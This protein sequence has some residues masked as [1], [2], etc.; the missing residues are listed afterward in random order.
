MEHVAAEPRDHAPQVLNLALR[1]GQPLAE[2][3]R[4]SFEPRFGHDFGRVRV[5]T[6]SAA[7]QSTEA[8]HA[9]A[10]T[11]GCD[12][13]FASG[14]YDTGSARGRALLAH[15]LA[16]VVQQRGAR[17]TRVPLRIER[18]DSATEAEARQVG[19]S[20]GGHVLTTTTTALMCADRDAV[21]QIRK[22]GRV[23]GA[24]IRF[25]PPNVTDTV[26]GPVTVQPGL[27]GVGQAQLSVI[28]GQN[29]TPRALARELLPLWTTATQFLP[30]GGGPPVRP[31]ALSVEQLARALI[32]YNQHY[33]GLPSMTSWAAGL[34]FPLPVEIDE[35]TGVATVSPA[36][37]R[38]LAGRFH[39][40]WATALDTRAPATTAPPA[41][42]VTADVAGF[43]AANPS[44][45]ARGMHLAARALTNA[46]AAL[47]IVIETFVQ[48]AGAGAFDVAL[49]FMDTLVNRG[50]GILARQRDGSA[51]LTV[52]R[53]NLASLPPTPTPGQTASLNRANVM[54]GLIASVRPSGRP[55]DRPV[56]PEKSVT[57][58]TVK[59]AGSSH[60]PTTQVQVAN[61]I[62]AQ[63]NVHFVHGA[64]RTATDA[65]TTGW[66]GADRN[67]AVAPACGAVSGEESALYG[68][69]NAT[70]GFG[71]RMRAIFARDFTGYAASGYSLPPYCATGAA[72]PFV[73][74][75]IVANSGDTSTL[76]H[77]LG[78]I[79]LN[80][81][82]HPAGTIMEPRPRPNEITAGQ[83]ATIYANA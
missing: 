46:S 11:L 76:A 30:P 67:V 5:H 10:Y 64:N 7:A 13:A 75:L 62:Y 56:R 68:G 29:L 74:H 24:A 57:I 40:A 3:T 35:T 52:I 19:A 4:R 63:C 80:S 36:T 47:P 42:T 66:I 59:L 17:D 48:L 79:L 18:T 12:I 77:E 45:V 69:I 82:G 65:Q 27:L 71:S 49:T 37:I 54:F 72:A 33:L 26:I 21:G 32:V 8:V 39:P 51:I 31:G 70:F 41:A 53:N 73:N 9:R 14:E 78:H 60:N 50:M 20:G 34:R 15:E 58:D 22:L 61:A 25:I 1:S 43:L 55:A 38:T 23:V 44:D 28:I 16:H 83:C 81:G 6:D 2:S